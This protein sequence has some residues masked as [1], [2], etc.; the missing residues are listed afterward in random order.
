MFHEVPAVSN[1]GNYEEVVNL[2]NTNTERNNIYHNE[3][4]K[5]LFLFSAA[6]ALLDREDYLPAIEEF[7]G[8]F[9]TNFITDINILRAHFLHVARVN[10]PAAKNVK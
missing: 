4:E 10:C 3:P 1:R 2:N 8:H 7:L 9:S 5:I 6:L